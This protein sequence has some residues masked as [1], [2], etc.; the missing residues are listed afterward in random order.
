MS[1]TPQKPTE[2]DE[3][4]LGKLIPFISAEVKPKLPLVSVTA[5]PEYGQRHS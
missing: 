3:M 5:L 4:L 1:Q 2:A